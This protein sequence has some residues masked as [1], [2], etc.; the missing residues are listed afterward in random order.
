[1][2]HHQLLLVHT[3]VPFGVIIAYFLFKEKPS[4]K[5]ILGMI[6]AFIGL[7]VLLGAPNLQG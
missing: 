2:H 4:L 3:E 1:M 7:F 5:S 6:I